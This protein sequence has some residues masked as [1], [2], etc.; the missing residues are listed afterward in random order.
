MQKKPQEMTVKQ[1]ASK[2]HKEKNLLSR[3]E[4]FS[5][6]SEYKLLTKCCYMLNSNLV[7]IYSFALVRTSKHLLPKCNTQQPKDRYHGRSR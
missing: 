7:N 1:L 5:F 2:F 3:E 4:H 6:S